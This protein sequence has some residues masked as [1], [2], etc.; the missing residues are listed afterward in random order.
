MANAGINSAE[1][2]PMINQLAVGV[3]Y[4]AA[5]YDSP[6]MKLSNKTPKSALGQ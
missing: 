3:L 1:Y 5:Q 6:K 4:A 2:R